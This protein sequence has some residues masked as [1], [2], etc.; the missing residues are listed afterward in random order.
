MINLLP[1]GKKDDILAARANVILLRYIGIIVIAFLFTLLIFS[2]SK[3]VLSGTMETAQSR[4]ETNSV[5][6]DVY[7]STQQEVSALSSKLSDTK[8]L[9]N[10]DIRYSQ[11]LTELGRL[12]P[13]GVI[14][15]Q[16]TLN[17]ATFNGT[18]L[19]LTAY[20][21]STAEASTLQTQLQ[22]SSLFSQVSLQQTDTSGGI[23]GYP[24]AIS[25]NVSLN[26]GGLSR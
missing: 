21:R 18:P 2:T 6:A 17:D 26:K 1:N 22:S 9:L 19:K 5:K 15:K 3:S 8:A 20:A 12:T 25:L 13:A 7:S 23:S 24:V 4:I 16:L 11:V 14:I 10:N